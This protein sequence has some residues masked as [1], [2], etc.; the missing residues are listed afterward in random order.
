MKRETEFHVWY[1]IAAVLGILVL[2]Y[3]WTAAEQVESVPY[4]QLRTDLI[5]G[6]IADV[7]VSDRY[8]YATLKER[9]KNGKKQIIADRVDPELASELSKYKVTFSG[10]HAD[11]FLSNIL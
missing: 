9:L 6:K 4:S 8:I 3:F 1:V 5:D 2:Q 10:T 11:T 7:S